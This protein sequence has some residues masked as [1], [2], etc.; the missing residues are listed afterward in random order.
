MLPT[1]QGGSKDKPKKQTMGPFVP[2]TEP[3]GSIQSKWMNDNPEA[4]VSRQ[5]KTYNAGTPLKSL[6]NRP[7]PKVNTQSVASLLG[8]SDSTPE[9]PS[10]IA[11][12][13]G[14]LLQE[15]ARKAQADAAAR[16]EQEKKETVKQERSKNKFTIS[17]GRIMSIGSDGE[18]QQLPTGDSLGEAAESFAARAKREM[19]MNTSAKVAKGGEP[20]AEGQPVGKVKPMSWEEY[21][22][23]SPRARAA[24]DF[25]TMLV[26]AVNKDKASQ[27]QYETSADKQERAQ[28]EVGVQ[29]MFGDER[30]SDLYAP[31]TM[32]VLQQ[33]KFKDP[34]ADLDDF[35]GLKAAITEDD[36]KTIDDNFITKNQPAELPD[37]IAAPKTLANSADPGVRNPLTEN[38]Q[39]R[40]E[41]VMGLAL[42]TERAIDQQMSKAQ[43]V[44]QNFQAT[45]YAERS[46]SVGFLGGTPSTVELAPGYGDDQLSQ[47]IQS[48]YT[49]LTTSD[50][51]SP[52]IQSM[53]T[54]LSK[55]RRAGDPEARQFYDYLSTRV[56]Q[57]KTY[58][59]PLGG[60]DVKYRSAEQL[61]SALGL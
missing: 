2:G 48:A 35:L 50:P 47:M 49:Q 52:E 10:M 58:G 1:P 30:G 21:E 15:G 6:L 42:G 38:Q 13:E 54:D 46:E 23:L 56:D 59:T 20:P 26:T 5:A 39:E 14:S 61:A 60:E 29:E 22:A 18:E 7:E 36:L 28:Y 33:I 40:R 3:K 53:L 11:R 17:G 44:L 31:E 57:N 37:K 45:A 25:N 32:A 16:A 19:A 34:Q 8:L 51:N 4:P 41:M 43:G 27:K 9:V 55:G 12:P 24:V